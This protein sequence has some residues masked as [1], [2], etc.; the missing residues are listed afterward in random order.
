MGG[1]QGGDR[2]EVMQTDRGKIA[3]LICYD[4]EFPELARVAVERG[5]RILFVPF[6]TNDRAGTM[7]VK[8]CAHARCIENHVYAVTAGCVGHLPQVAN[9][10]LHYAI[11]EVLT[12]CDVAFPQ[13]GVAV[14]T[15]PS[16]EEMILQDLDLEA[17]RRHRA[18]GTVR[19]WHDRREDLYEVRWLGAQDDKD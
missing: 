14:S 19:N 16:V 15:S 7:R 5:A 3:I 13:D 10:D 8:V 2:V 9:A 6:N 17:L 12:P 18:T 1:V 4:C 11:S